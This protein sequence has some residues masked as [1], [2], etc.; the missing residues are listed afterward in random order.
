MSGLLPL[1]GHQAG[2]ILHRLRRVYEFVAFYTVF[3]TFGLSCLA[4]S[5]PAAALHP[6][7]PRRI[8]APLGQFMIMAGFRGFVGLMR[9]TGLFRCD[10]AALDSLRGESGLVIAANHPSLL[11]AVL[12]I[13]R[14]PRVVCIMKPAIWG[15][16][17]LGGGARLA[18]YIRSDKPLALVRHAAR[19]L[20]DGHQL[21]IFPEGTRTTR[22]PVNAFKG[23]FALIARGAGAPIQTVFIETNSPFLGKGWRFFSLPRFPLVF[24]ARL[25]RRFDA[26]ENAASVSAR[27]ETYFRQ[28]LGEG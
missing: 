26:A 11:D 25:G 16:P 5:L 7:L 4:W 14:L 10:L 27:L 17:F 19:E 8:G 12:V 21:L 1:R 13:S 23:G 24:R 28:E 3:A 22:P 2:V 15:N 6:L 18:C 9:L 20:R